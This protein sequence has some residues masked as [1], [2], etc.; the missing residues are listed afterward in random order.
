MSNDT[1]HIVFEGQLSG[2]KSLPETKQQ[3]AT[4]FKMNATQVEALFTGKPVAIKRNVDQDT[5]KKYLAA[6]KKAGAVCKVVNANDE[7]QTPSRDYANTANQ[8][9]SASNTAGTD[10]GITSDRMAGKDIVDL[11]IPDAIPNFGLGQPGDAIPTL[12]DN[13]KAVIPDTSGLS[14]STDE[15]YLAPTKDIPEPKVDLGNLSIK[16]D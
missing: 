2:E 15:K 1:Y 16:N 11:N 4:M 10:S 9:K 5:A 6:F 3:L 14:F 7:T 8:Q 13:K 12:K